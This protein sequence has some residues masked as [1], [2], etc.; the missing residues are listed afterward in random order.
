MAVDEQDGMA[1]K[2]DWASTVV[3][4]WKHDE[5]QAHGMLFK[6]WSAL[7]RETAG[8]DGLMILTAMI[9]SIPS[10]IGVFASLS[11]GAPGLA[12]IALLSIVPMSALGI[13]VMSNSKTSAFFLRRFKSK[14]MARLYDIV[15]KKCWK[16]KW[17]PVPQLRDLNLGKALS[18]I[19]PSW[20]IGDA[21]AA[22]DDDVRKT[23]EAGVLDEDDL[24]VVLETL[25]SLPGDEPTDASSLVETLVDRLSICIDLKDAL[26]RSVEKTTDEKN[27]QAEKA[28][29]A[30]S[31]LTN[32]MVSSQDDLLDERLKLEAAAAQV[33]ID[34]IREEAV[35]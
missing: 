1:L 30:M 5:R 6:Y 7:E 18:S 14:L 12:L 8:S 17:N 22:F 19:A 26:K 28:D 10:I 24:V 2:S 11:C 21:A 32:A 25:C 27:R 4:A 20:W 23:W 3:E 31:A 34:S 13:T 35:A 29:S 33:A 15:D 16:S 9:A